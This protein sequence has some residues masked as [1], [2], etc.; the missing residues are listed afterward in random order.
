MA[1]SIRERL[2]ALQRELDALDIG[3]EKAHDQLPAVRPSST[4]DKGPR[5]WATALTMLDARRGGALSRSQ[6]CAIVAASWVRTV[7]F[8]H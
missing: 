7:R 3:P 8:A 6:A 4:L 5:Q 2:E 1:G